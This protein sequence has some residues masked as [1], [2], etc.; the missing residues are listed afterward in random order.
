MNV[1]DCSFNDLSCY[2]YK[3]PSGS[4]SL[5]NVNGP[6]QV[7]GLSLDLQKL[8]SSMGWQYIPSNNNFAG[9][10]SNLSLNGEVRFPEF[11]LQCY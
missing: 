2:V 9:C 1:D 3:L 10:I 11:N 7:G 5:L 4:N 6:L 8:R